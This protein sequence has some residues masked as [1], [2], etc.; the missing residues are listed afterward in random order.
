MKNQYFLLFA[1]LFS[2]NLLAQPV[3]IYTHRY[4]N[5]RLGWTARETQLNTSNV[6]PNDFGLVFKRIVDDQIYAQPLVVSDLQI[7]GGTHNVLFVATVNNTVYAFDADDSA[8]TTPYWQVN[9]THLG[10]RVIRNT[11]MTG[12]CGGNYLDFSGHMG[13]VGTPVIDSA[14][15]TMY[16]V[17]REVTTAGGQFKQYL[18]ALDILTGTER[19]GSPVLISG[20]YAG[21]GVGNSG[22]IIQFEQQKENQRPALLLFNNV[23]YI[24]WASHCDWGPYHGWMIGY[25]ATTLQK[26]CTYNTTPDGTQGGIWMAGAGPVVDDS[27]YVYL[28]TGNGTV[29]S[30]GNPNYFR[31]RGES[32]LKLRPVGDSMQVVNFFTPA[33]YQYLNQYDLDYGCDGALLIPNSSLVLSGTKEGNLYM[34]NTNHMGRYTAGNDSVLQILVANDQSINNVH[35]HGTPVYCSFSTSQGDS[36]CI[37]V[38]AE[39]DTLRQFFFNRTTMLFDTVHTVHGTI[40]LDNG[41]PGAMLS[42]SS[43]GQTTGSGIVWANHPLSGNANQ[44][45]RPGRF[46]AFDARNVQHLLWSSQSIPARDSV[47]AFAKFNT[48]VVANGK[49]YLATFSNALNVY[50]LLNST[51]GLHDLNEDMHFASIYPNPAGENVTISYSMKKD[52]PQLSLSVIDLLGRR[53]MEVELPPAAGVQTKTISFAPG[54]SAGVYE[55]VLS[56]GGRMLHVTKLVKE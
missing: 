21:N 12:A 43:A 49:V 23:V 51:T 19:T 26:V 46:D 53:V 25:N 24:C 28:T 38:W 7:G 10:S 34:V 54:M 9:L 22:G 1:C 33:N 47:G 36:E 15:G 41:M 3:S 39:S 5:K 8:T 6:N 31:D 30:T 55:A 29:G 18:H 52:L 35:I 2:F 50:G 56:S 45:V 20:S 17:S 4:N 37:Y 27:G 48:P 11:D 14:S 42:V 32:I 13:I 44:Q 40:G 16:L